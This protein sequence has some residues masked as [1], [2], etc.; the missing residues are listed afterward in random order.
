MRVRGQ[1]TDLP[2]PVTERKLTGRV[3]IRNTL[4]ENLYILSPIALRPHQE[5]SPAE[6]GGRL[7][8]RTADPLRVK[9]VL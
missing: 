4:S 9:Q 7:R 5:N 8:T 6:D 1:L 2:A 3:S